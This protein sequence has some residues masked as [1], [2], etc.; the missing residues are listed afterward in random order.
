M[1]SSIIQPASWT[2]FLPLNEIF[3]SNGPL[4]VDVGC[5]KGRFLA[6]RAKLNSLTNFL[7]IDRLLRRLRNVDRKIVCEGLSNVRLLRVEASYAIKHLLPL[8]AVSVFFFF[9][10]DP[11]PK[12]KHHRR[13]LFSQSFLDSL[14]R[15]LLP[16]GHVHLAT[17]HMNYFD[18]VYDM[19]GQDPRF[20]EMPA[21]KPS[22]EE[23]TE[24]ELL[25]RKQQARICRCS[26]Q[27]ITNSKS[28]SH[29]NPRAIVK[30]NR[31][32]NHKPIT[33]FCSVYG[34]CSKISQPPAQ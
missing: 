11:W 33:A 28:K 9:F 6:S 8:Q 34:A 23:Q 17:D 26:F 31:S 10:P 27:K 13:R 30:Q 12:R 25:F 2:Q 24:F 14:H 19:F 32:G 21:F 5:G 7:G 20:S 3:G 4:E 29:P 18:N 15:T 16:G 22:E 1:D